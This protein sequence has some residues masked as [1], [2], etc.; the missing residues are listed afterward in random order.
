MKLSLLTFAL[1]I[2]GNAFSMGDASG[3]RLPTRTMKDT[4]STLNQVTP[5][6][7]VKR[8]E[9]QDLQEQ[10]YQQQQEREE[11]EWEMEKHIL[12]HRYDRPDT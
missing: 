5:E 9:P 4:V 2:S 10:I 3:I 8:T 12:D 1:L 11:K 7:E 6:Q